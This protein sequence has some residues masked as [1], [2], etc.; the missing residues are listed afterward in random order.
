MGL[1]D[2]FRAKPALL[3]PSNAEPRIDA[4]PPAGWWQKRID[5]LQNLINGLGVKGV[6]RRMGMEIY[7]RQPLVLSQQYYLYQQSWKARRACEIVPQHACRAWVKLTIP[8]NPDASARLQQVI[9]PYKT[10]IRTAGIWANLTGGGLCAL[11]VDDGMDASVPINFRTVKG[12]RNVQVF[13][14]WYA[15]PVAWNQDPNQWRF[16]EPDAYSVFGSAIASPIGSSPLMQVH[17]SR[18]L[19]IDG[20]LLPTMLRQAN[21]G[22]NSSV[23]EYCWD[24]LRDHQQGMDSGAKALTAFSQLFIKRVGFDQDVI[25]PGGETASD[26]R[27]SILS[28]QLGTGGVAMLD[29][30][31]DISIQSQRMAGYSDV[32]DRLSDELAGAFNIPRS[33]LYGQAR[34]VAKAGAESDMV[35]FY[36]NVGDWMESHLIPVVR[37]LVAILLSTPE[38]RGLG[39]D[40][41]DVLI[42]ANSLWE[43]D[44]K[45]VAEIAK[46]NADA[47]VALNGTGALSPEQV[48]LAAVKTLAHLDMAP[49]ESLLESIRLEPEPDRLDPMDQAPQPNVTI[50]G[51]GGMPPLAGLN[52]MGMPIIPGPD[53]GPGG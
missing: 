44:D 39:L 20:P 8:D 24:A 16:G 6:D 3:L 46:L 50:Q 9:A 36:D 11:I 37:Q 34:G 1:L 5:S 30:A 38:F 27:L 29:A 25:A 15:Y 10:A 7:Q 28:Q 2:R 26:L 13:D 42:E 51:Q 53:S 48:H 47:V 49:D 40:A 32:L 35:A 31:D 17:S 21:V 4:N 43:M 12:V 22:W 18:C 19:R 33:L 52:G 41:D 14:R 45:E 23:L